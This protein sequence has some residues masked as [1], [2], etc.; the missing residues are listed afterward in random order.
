MR[1]LDTIGKTQMA[2]DLL[3]DSA[4]GME[5]LD[6]QQD[7]VWFQT[8]MAWLRHEA[9]GFSSFARSHSPSR[10]LNVR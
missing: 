1:I 10:L 7:P 8:N 3:V 9:T 2:I 6:M 4:G 5:F